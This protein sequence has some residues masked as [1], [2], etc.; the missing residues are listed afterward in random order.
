MT[1]LTRVLA[2]LTGLAV[3][4][5]G[6]VVV[7]ETVMLLLARPA[8]V[9]PRT[10][11]DSTLRRLTWDDPALPALLSGLLV[12]GALMLLG[13]LW[14]RRPSALRLTG[15][16]PSR[17]A[18]IDASGLAHR[19]AG[20]ALQDVDVLHARV[21]IRR[22]AARVTAFA[23]RDADPDTVRFRLRRDLRETLEATGLRRSM[24]IRVAVREA[25]ERVR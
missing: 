14:P 6:V 24:R 5:A 1:V 9:V 16:T 8:L 13:M 3:A 15:T 19:L 4:A 20:T 7:V 25:R 18:D 12:V 10:T 23:P 11:W 22:R 2:L 21:R 17:K